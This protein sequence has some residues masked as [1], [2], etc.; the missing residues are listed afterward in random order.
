MSHSTENVACTMA[1]S[2]IHSRYPD[3]PRDVGCQKACCR[4]NLVSVTD[5]LINSI[6][7]P[8]T[9]PGLIQKTL[10]QFKC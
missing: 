3:F 8:N 6:R 1:Y 5:Q 7:F 4:P 9:D 2:T 10:R